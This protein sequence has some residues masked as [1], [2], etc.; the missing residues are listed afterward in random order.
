MTATRTTGARA[1][2]QALQR[3][4]REYILDERLSSGVPMPPEQVL[5]ERFG[6]SRHP[7]REAMKALEAVGIVDIRHGSGTFVGI[8]S[9]TALREGLEFRAALS[10]NG[11]LLAARELLQVRRLLESGLA[12]EVLARR[13]ELDMP[14]LRSAVSRMERAAADGDYEAS[15]D[16]TFHRLLYEPIGNGLILELLE[17]FWSVFHRLDDRLPQGS[18]TP[19]VIA[20]WHADILAAIDAADR[21]HMARAVAAHFDGISQ[22]LG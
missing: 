14:A 5:M 8:G 22:R 12:G 15:A 9:L 13:D 10:L 17:V 4:I 18:A 6:V 20:G 21:D 1:N 7:L 19:E 3:A 2:Q 16:W 11:D